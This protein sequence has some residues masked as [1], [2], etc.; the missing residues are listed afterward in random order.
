MEESSP[1]MAAGAM[2]SPPMTGRCCTCV[3]ETTIG[4]GDEVVMLAA[5]GM[6]RRKSREERVGAVV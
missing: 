1:A 6:E 3:Q 5:V 2:E 4:Q